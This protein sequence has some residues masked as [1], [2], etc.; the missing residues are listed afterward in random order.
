MAKKVLLVEYEPRYLQRLNSVLQQKGWEIQVAKDGEEALS[1]LE[2]FSP[3]LVFISAVLPKVRTAE[4]IKAIKSKGELSNTKIVL[5][6]TGIKEDLIEVEKKKKEVDHILCKPFSETKIIEVLDTFTPPPPAE[7]KEEGLLDLIPKAEKKLTSEDLFGE[8][9]EE[10][11]S[12]PKVEK[13]EEVE[14]PSAPKVEKKEEVEDLLHKTLSSIPSEKAKKTEGIPKLETDIDK[15]LTETL[16][17]I[18]IPTK[19]KKTVQIPKEEPPKVEVEK[20]KVEEIKPKVEIKEAPKIV[21][22]VVEEVKEKE[23][24]KEE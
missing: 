22:K 17:G 12:A 15:K 16:S 2:V 3:D 4:V 1:K 19:P 11:P 7:K 6:A 21:E 8:F 14:K 18:Q 24:P 9:I 5:L 23:K 20:P 10:K 13:K